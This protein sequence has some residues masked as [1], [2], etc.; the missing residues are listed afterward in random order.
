MK[1]LQIPLLAMAMASILP[2]L[3]GQAFENGNA[4][5][6]PWN[7]SS[8][9]SFFPHFPGDP[10]D[11]TQRVSTDEKGNFVSSKNLLAKGP[12]AISFYRGVW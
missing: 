10:I 11:E 3:K 6:L 12:L 9:S 8:V 7:D 1:K 4:F 5:N 2:S